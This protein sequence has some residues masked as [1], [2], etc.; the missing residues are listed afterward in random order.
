M[1][2][3]PNDPTQDFFKWW[4]GKYGDYGLR[5]EWPQSIEDA[6]C[7]AWKAQAE[8]I[9]AQTQMIKDLHGRIKILTE[10]CCWLNSVGPDKKETK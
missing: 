9:E 4:F 1:D 2:D 5:C 7:F 10:E 6:A 8:I 3:K